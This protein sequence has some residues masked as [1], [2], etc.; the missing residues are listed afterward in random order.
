MSEGEAVWPTS[1]RLVVQTQ[2]VSGVIEPENKALI[3]PYS[4][5][6]QQAPNS[7]LEA[8]VKGTGYLSGHLEL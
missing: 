4:R 1:Q 7:E 8:I 5:T 2:M 6:W 3:A